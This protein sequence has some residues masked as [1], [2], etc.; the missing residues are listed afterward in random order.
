[1]IPYGRQC[2]DEDDIN[3]VVETLRSEY[4]TTGPKVAEFEEAV[5]HFVGVK[6]AV[7]VSSGT[8]A[9]H[10]A[11]YALGVEP[12]DEVIIPVMTFAAT[13]SS[14]V[15][16]GATPVFADV[17]SETLLIDLNEVQKKITNKTKA[18]IAVDYAGQPCDYDTL[19]KIAEHH[20]LSLVAD[21]CHALG[22][23]CKGCAVGSLAD[24]NV[25]SFHPVKHIT[26]GEGG[27][28]TTD[29]PEL[30]QRMRVFRNHGITADHFQRETESSWFYE[31]HELGCNYRITDFQCALGLMQLNK[32]PLFLERRR[33]IAKRY[34]EAFA[35]VPEI[36]PLAVKNNKEKQKGGG[37][38]IKSGLGLLGPWRTRKEERKRGKEGERERG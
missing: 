25:F 3:A 31:I 16:V 6:Y 24:L 34:D 21:A 29:N 14:V 17:D 2:V 18:I 8:A 20:G 32:L 27:M 7:A 28:I 26:T 37:R 9:L 35:N 13:A 5:A 36:S 10:T 11:I 1:M 22:G 33:E 4:L 23:W 19:R 12:G 38:R 30:A 15:F